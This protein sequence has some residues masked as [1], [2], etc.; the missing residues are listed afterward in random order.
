MFGGR[1]LK[2]GARLIETA[3]ATLSHVN[4]PDRTSVVK[5]P[6]AIRRYRLN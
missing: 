6:R 2:T 4:P 5:A 3:T 1:F